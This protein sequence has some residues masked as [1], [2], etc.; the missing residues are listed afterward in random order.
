MGG[1]TVTHKPKL[2]D[3]VREKIRAKHYSIRTEQAYLAWIKKFILYHN[4][5]HPK[6]MGAP[7]IN[8]F[9]SNLANQRDRKSVV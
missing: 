9:L 6:D 7:E 1:E 4:K 5:K 3:I 8:Q 2:L